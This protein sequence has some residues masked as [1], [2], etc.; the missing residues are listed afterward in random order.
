[1]RQLTLDDLDCGESLRDAAI[2]QVAA[3]A[4]PSWMAEAGQVLDGLIARGGEF[5]TDQLWEVLPSCPEPRAM[6]AVIRSAARAGRIVQ[7]G[8]RRS[9]R[10]AC[11][12]R[13]IPV[14]KGKS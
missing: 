12:A 11:H 6:G 2:E 9:S 13:P 5:T 4:P 3:Y 1:M 7:T 10:A 8:Y 14:W